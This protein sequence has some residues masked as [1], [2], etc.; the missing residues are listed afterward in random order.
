MNIFDI[1]IIIVLIIGAGAGARKGF[2]SQLFSLIGIVGGIVVAIAYGEAVGKMLNLDPAYSKVLGFAITFIANPLETILCA[3]FRLSK[4]TSWS[5]AF[6]S[7]VYAH[8]Q[9]DFCRL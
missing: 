4:Y 8:S 2:I 7:K 6:S 5:V 9:C 3:G 1:I